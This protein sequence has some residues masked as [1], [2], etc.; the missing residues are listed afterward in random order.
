MAMHFSTR[1]AHGPVLRRTCAGLVLAALGLALAF[2]GHTAHPPADVLA[3]TKADKAAKTAKAGK[4]RQPGQRVRAPAQRS[5]SEETP[6]QRDRRL[7]R[8]CQGRH[9]AGACAGYTQPPPGNR[10]R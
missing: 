8:E 1:A 4:R 2:P 10:Q 9:N 7:Y 6:E 3:T 5:G